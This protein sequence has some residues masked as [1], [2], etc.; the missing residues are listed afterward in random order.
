MKVIIASTI[1]PFIE[2][3]GT[4]IVDWLETMLTEFG[5]DVE[6]LKIPFVSSYRELPSQMLAL[7]LLDVTQHADRLITIRPPAHLLRHPNKVIW[8][9]HH[10]RG[11]YDLWGTIYQDLPNTPE[12]LAYRE[13]IV[14]SDHLGF[15]E[16]RRICSNSR[17]TAQRLKTF[18]DIDAEVLYPPVIRPERYRCESYGDYILYMSRIAHHKRQALAIESM[19]Y[20]RTAVKL[21]IAGKGDDPADEESLRIEV[22]KHGVEDKVV[23]HFGW[24]S[25]EEKVDLFADCLAAIYIPFN[26]DSYGYPSLEA[27]HAGK[28]VITTTDAGGT[29]ELIVNGENGFV[30]EPSPQAIA[31][32]MDRLYLDRSLARKL[33]QAGIHRIKKLGIS[34]PHVI[35]RLIA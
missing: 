3:G 2:G 26:E 9:I 1:V 34:W 24:I 11:A 33:G 6:V 5:H 8:F 17:E 14:K 25:E 28:A 32:S 29:K 19:R 23:L 35:D 4:F 31:E 16:A 18:N 20:T 15:S 12:G 10:H 7:R 21:T 30:V 13:A 22:A 27:H